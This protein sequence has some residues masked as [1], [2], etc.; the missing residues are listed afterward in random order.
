MGIYLCVVVKVSAECTND[1]SPR[2]V[3]HT[4]GSLGVTRTV[5]KY[6]KTNPPCHSAII[7]V[8]GFSLLLLYLLL[9]FS[10]YTRQTLAKRSQRFLLSSVRRRAYHD[11]DIYGYRVP[12]EY[13][14]P[15]YT[16]EE[17]SNRMAYGSLLRLVQ[18]YRTHG[19][20]SA[21]LDPLDIMN[22]E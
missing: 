10:C 7:F 15:D 20:K 16:A 12:K 14:M 21:Q 8:P 9:M 19:H 11:R 22:H 2:F 4:I 3:P 13:Q 6:L 18:A 1:T 17:L 5:V